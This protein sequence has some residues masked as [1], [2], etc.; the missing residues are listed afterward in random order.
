M[1]SH[2]WDSYFEAERIVEALVEAGIVKK[3]D[4]LKARGI[5]QIKLED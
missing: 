4:S 2:S 3:K 1:S 5:V